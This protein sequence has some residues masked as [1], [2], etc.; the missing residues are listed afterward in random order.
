MA[1]WIVG[2]EFLRLMHLGLRS[3]LGSSDCQLTVHVGA[4][5]A[6]N[7]DDGRYYANSTAHIDIIGS[8]KPSSQK[9]RAGDLYAV[10]CR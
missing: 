10:H 7:R 9:L 1:N 5:D 8:G 6:T 2:S 3:V 4:K